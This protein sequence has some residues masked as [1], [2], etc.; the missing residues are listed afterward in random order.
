MELYQQGA[1]VSVFT[2]A[3]MLWIKKFISKRFLP[4]MSIVI[5]CSLSGMLTVAFGDGD[6]KKAVISGL[7]GGASSMGI[8]DT[9]SSTRKKKK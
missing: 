7:A 1:A 4:V 5:A 6:W 2:Y 9:M 3:I 8:H